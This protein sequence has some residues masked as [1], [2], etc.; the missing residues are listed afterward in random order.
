[1]QGLAQ[2]FIA[3]FKKSADARLRISRAL[4]RIDAPLIS[5]FAK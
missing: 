5:D 3:A 2:R 1:M 4:T